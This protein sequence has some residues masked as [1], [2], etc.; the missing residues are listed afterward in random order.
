M[1]VT[2]NPLQFVP[3][4]LKA[5]LAQNAASQI[6]DDAAARSTGGTA[7]A[8]P[9]E[10]GPAPDPGAVA[11]SVPQPPPAMPSPLGPV[12][13]N[14]SRFAMTQAPARGQLIPSYSQASEDVRAGVPG[15][16]RGM[17]KLGKLLFLTNAVAGG[18]AAG[19][20]Q[21]GFGTGWMAGQ[22]YG[23]Q[24]DQFGLD[25][26]QRRLGLQQSQLGI[27]TARENL[28]QLPL[29]REW[30]RQQREREAA[31]EKAKT[32]AYAAM[33]NKRDEVSLQQMHANA[34]QKA[35]NEGRDP[36]TDP[37]VQKYADAITALQKQTPVKA[38]KTNPDQE[39]FDYYTR[40]VAQGGMGLSPAQAYA[41]MHP[42]E[43]QQQ[44][45]GAGGAGGGFD[46][47]VAEGIPER[48][49]QLSPKNQ[50]AFQ[51]LSQKDPALVNDLFALADGRMSLDAWTNRQSK[52][53]TKL[54]KQDAGG[55]A[56]TL[57]PNWTQQTYK[58]RDKLMD[59]YGVG[60][61]SGLVASFNRFLQHSGDAMEV[62]DHWRGTGS[63]I[64]NTAMK[65]LTRLKDDPEFKRFQAA[66]I[67]VRDEFE[68]FIK[69]GHV[70]TSEE[71]DEMHTVLSDTSSPAAIE[72]AIKQLAKSGILQLDSLNSK[73]KRTMGTDFPGLIDPNTI[74]AH[75]V[76]L[77]GLNDQLQRYST[78]GM[79]P[80]SWAPGTP[81]APAGTPGA[82]PTDS[83]G[84]GG[85]PGKGVWGKAAKHGGVAMAG[86]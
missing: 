70:P 27:E 45:G 26:Q 81:G 78:E 44:G 85:V 55:I 75:G 23:N 1:S 12:F 65:N 67:P 62:T 24:Q 14:T 86:Q 19:S 73:W 11:S 49:A 6:S 2:T 77:L 32:D 41:K 38:E 83:S 72:A 82:T 7:P 51:A 10:P 84:R 60:K 54:T 76:G 33:A 9:P 52:Y 31:L 42:H 28:A 47:S 8:P 18:A 37:D 80:G 63:P 21:T 50:Q 40:P 25:Q 58:L 17:T 59:D 15:A 46:I 13:K 43:W 3:D 74:N 39:T 64:I 56:Q 20:T 22:Q 35:V 79:M 5:L 71:V 66:L 68:N 53:T 30:Q 57:N 16:A 29:Q 48:I 4:S 36:S 61:D 34:V 69:M